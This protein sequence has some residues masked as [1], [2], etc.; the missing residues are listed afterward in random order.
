[1]LSD[2]AKGCII[3]VCPGPEYVSECNS[4]KSH[5]KSCSRS[6]TEKWK[7]LQFKISQVLRNQSSNKTNVFGTIFSKYFQMFLNACFL[8]DCV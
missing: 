7:V 3:N 5:L 4:S 8:L 2:F 1:M 6:Y